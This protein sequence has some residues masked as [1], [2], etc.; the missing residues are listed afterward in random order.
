MGLRLNRI[1]PERDQCPEGYEYV[2]GHKERNGKYVRSFCR[3]IPRKRIRLSVDIRYPGNT[4]AKLSARQGL[5]GTS[6]TQEVPT[7]SLF[8]GED[9]KKMRQLLDSDWKDSNE[10]KAL[11]GKLEERKRKNDVE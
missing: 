2:H 10:L 6:F 11:S 4:S 5:H 1:D 9:G 8:A 7:E 3:K